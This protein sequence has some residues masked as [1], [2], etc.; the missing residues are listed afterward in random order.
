MVI[1]ATAPWATKKQN[2]GRQNQDL[3]HGRN[4]LEAN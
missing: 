1:A 2:P 3:F 4:S